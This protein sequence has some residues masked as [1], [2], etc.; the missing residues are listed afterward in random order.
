MDFSSLLD[1]VQTNCHIAD[2]RHARDMTMCTYLLEMRD[3]FRWENDLP[4]TSPPPREELGNWLIE[5]EAMWEGYE[6]LSFRK[7]PVGSREFDPFDAE[8]V[9][10][11]I[12]AHGLVYGGGYGRFMKPHFFLGQLERR[13]VLDGF[14]VLVSG[15]EYARDLTADVG[16]MRGDTIFVRREAV[17]RWLWTKAEGWEWVKREGA[18]ARALECYGFE[19]DRDAALDRMTDTEIESI[20]L[21]ELGEG[22]AGRLLPGWEDMVGSLKRRHSEILV[23]AAR[24]NLADCLET[25]PDLVERKETCAIHFYFANFDG[26]RKNIFPELLPAYQGFVDGDGGRALKDAARRGRK[27]WGEAC[28]R[29]LAAHA[30]HRGAAD[31]AAQ[32]ILSV[33]PGCCATGPE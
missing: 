7:V 28:L 23:R 14:N 33:Q 3:F 4:L 31:A 10:S 32:E 25:L 21:H 17:R 24:D 12:L 2:A 13:K 29:V 6:S 26:M 8:G 16:A 30:K 18:L 15:C 20:I 11:A 9:N 5:R 1:A 19:R 27:R 22:A